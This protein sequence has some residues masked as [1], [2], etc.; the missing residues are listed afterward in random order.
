M[1]SFFRESQPG[2][3]PDLWQVIVMDGTLHFSAVFSPG[4]HVEAIQVINRHGPPEINARLFPISRSACG[5]PD[6]G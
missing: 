4:I 1:R 3:C 5:R 6:P 2:G